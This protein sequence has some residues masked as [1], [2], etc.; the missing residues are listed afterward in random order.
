MIGKKPKKFKLLLDST[1]DGDSTST[2]FNKCDKKYPTII[3]IKATNGYRF[4][5]YTN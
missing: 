2:F 3:F 4:G 5:G 1:I